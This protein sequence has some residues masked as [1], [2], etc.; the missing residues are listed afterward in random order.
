[1]KPM[2]NIGAV[3]LAAGLSKRMGGPKLFLPYKGKPLFLQAVETAVSSGLDPVIL[4]VGKFEEQFREYIPSKHVSILKNDEYQS[5]MGSS[6]KHGIN[7]LKGNAIAAFVFLAD[8]PFIPSIVPLE[9]MKQYKQ[10]R[11][12]GYLI[13]QP[14]YM[15]KEGHP[16]LFDADLFDEFRDLQGDIGGR[17]I[18]RKHQDQ[19]KVVSFQ[20][21]FW[22]LDVDTPTDYEKIKELESE[23]D[24]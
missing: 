21:P 7:R 19:L 10:E 16:V 20:N 17:H 1:M 14:K 23:M 4:V 2:N 12:K 11:S 18:I 3:I 6:L 15:E 22:G 13:F 8:Q 5:G 9:I 24:V